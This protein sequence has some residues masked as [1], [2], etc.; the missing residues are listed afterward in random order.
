MDGNFTFFRILN[1][2]QVRRIYGKVLSNLGVDTKEVVIN[3]L[4]DIKNEDP[5]MFGNS[6]DD[7][8]KAI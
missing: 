5:N 1:H 7:V 4:S 3:L 6:V 2:K 8:L